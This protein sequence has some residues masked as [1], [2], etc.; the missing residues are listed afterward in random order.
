MKKSLIIAMGVL[1]CAF[2]PIAAFAQNDIGSLYSPS[3]LSTGGITTAVPSPYAD[4]LNPASSG[5]SQRG[6]VDINYIGLAGLGTTSGWGNVANLGITIPTPIGV[7][8][9]SGR[10]IGSSFPTLDLGNVGMFNLSFSKDIYPNLYVGAGLDFQI[11]STWGLGLDLGFMDMPGDLWILKDFKWGAALRNIGKGYTSLGGS[12]AGGVGT[13]PP[14]F[15][16]AIGA[17]FNLLKTHDFALGLTPDLSFPSFQ[18]VRFTMGTDFTY[19]D[20]LRVDAAY[21]AD[22]VDIQKG[23]ARTIPFSLGVSFNLKTDVKKQIAFLGI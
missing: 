10:Y 16:P 23:T 4:I 3:S 1:L 9:G 7:F 15:T 17:S 18:D 13:T 11:G 5:G 2:I 6:V 12:A 19:R 20:F 21:V 14:A 8:S 22:L